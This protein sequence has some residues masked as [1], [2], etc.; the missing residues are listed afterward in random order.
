MSVKLKPGIATEGVSRSILAQLVPCLCRRP[1]LQSGLGVTLVQGR[2]AAEV[3][4][5][6]A[7]CT[8]RQKR[9]ARNILVLSAPHGMATWALVVH[10]PSSS[11]ASTD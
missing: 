1:V 8:R 3:E 6:R 2:G 9:G 11:E 5:K 10:Y 7:G 4:I